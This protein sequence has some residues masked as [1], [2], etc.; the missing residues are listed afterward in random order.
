M[1]SVFCTA[2]D[3]C[4]PQSATLVWNVTRQARSA[5][6]DVY[7]GGSGC[8]RYAPFGVGDRDARLPRP[9]CE[10]VGCVDLFMEVWIHA[11]KAMHAR[12]G[13]LRDTVPGAALAYLATSARSQL[14]ELNRQQRVARGGVA[15]PQ[16]TDGTIGRIAASMGGPWLADVF[17]FLLGTRRLPAARDLRHARAAAGAR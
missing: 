8:S 1:S 9:T 15:K 2:P 7:G 12:F 6:H 17:R 14:A 13:D 16:R 5:L 4:L 11:H 10:S 3:V